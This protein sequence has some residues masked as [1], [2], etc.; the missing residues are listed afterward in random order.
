[1]DE[2]SSTRRGAARGTPTSLELSSDDPVSTQRFLEG[3]FGWTFPAPP[4]P[5]GDGVEFRTS[6]GGEGRLHP[7]ARPVSPDRVSRV[8]VD[9]LGS[10][11][12][13]AQRAGGSLLLPRVD[14]PGMGSFFV[15]RIPG[16]PILTCWEAGASSAGRRR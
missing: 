5:N 12:D 15:I 2:P 3:V 8:R 11:L 13:R 10:V 9:D 4:A 16:G 1:M 6:D 14:A 7:S